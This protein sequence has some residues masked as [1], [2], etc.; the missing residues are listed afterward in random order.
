MNP[1]ELL[2]HRQR[3]YATAFRWTKNQEE[4]HDIASESLAV[5]LEKLGQYRGSASPFTWLCAIALNIHRAKF[6]KA[7]MES[8][9]ALAES[10]ADF[11]TTDKEP[12]D[13]HL[14]LAMARLKDKH[15]RA[16]TDHF[17][18]EMPVSQMAKSY[19]IPV[20]TVLSRIHGGKLELRQLCGVA[21]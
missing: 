7:R 16:L 14:A 2:A 20:G 13:N 15:R 18:N 17:L 1:G 21:L 9:D 5:A 12:T 4:A 19:R 6:R 3:L 8:L 11:G 10:G